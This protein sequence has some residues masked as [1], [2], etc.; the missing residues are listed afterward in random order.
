MQLLNTLVNIN[1]REN[2]LQSHIIIKL[3]GILVLIGVQL[4]L[5]R[6]KVHWLLNH[7]IVICDPVFL[8]IDWCME[9]IAP[10]DL[11]HVRHDFLAGLQPLLHLLEDL[12]LFV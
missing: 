9:D 8:H 3:L 1:K 11:P 10:F 2:K 6:A 7:I 5:D 12:C 4:N